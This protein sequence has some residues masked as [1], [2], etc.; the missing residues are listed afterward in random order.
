MTKELVFENLCYHDVRNPYK[1]DIGE[2]EEK[3]ALM[4]Q[5]ETCYCDNCFY[6]RTKLAEYILELLKEKENE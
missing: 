2:E 5:N 1:I 3:I 6:G 4:G